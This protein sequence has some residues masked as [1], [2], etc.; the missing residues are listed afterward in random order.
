MTLKIAIVG[1][2]K[3]ADGHVEEIQKIPELA[4]VVAVADLELL[5]AE[6]LAVRYGLPAHYDDLA[7]LLD[8]QRPDVV[9]VTTP[10]QSHLALARQAIAA[11]AHV[12]VEK[13]LAP[14]Y[15]EARAL[16][17]LARGAGKKLTIG[18][19][20]YFDP[21]LAALR[22]L[23]EEGVLG[24]P[25][26]VESFLGY[27]LGSAFGKALL[28][29]PEHWVHRLPG[30]LFQN[31]LDHVLCKLP[32][33]LPDGRPDA[34]VEADPLG[35][36]RIRA[37]GWR[38]R[39]ERFGD[40]RDAMLDELRVELECEGTSALA[41]FSAHVRPATQ[42]V[43]VHGSRNTALAH[44]GMSTLTLDS[45]PR[46]PSALGRLG[47]AFGQTGQFFRAG[48]RNVGRFARNEFHYFTGLRCL[49]ERF[50]E[51]IASDGPPPIPYRDLLRVSAWMDEIWRQ[52]PQGDRP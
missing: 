10:P 37:H 32:A 52:V 1:C 25:V 45:E 23:H 35:A 46:L 5:M 18:Y 9:H 7:R 20:Y 44:H 51:C 16:V 42:L 24:A 2:G 30:K 31:N 19:S 17:A 49:F 34:E 36:T 4:R 26:H 41:W 8:E 39:P 11:G 28:A 21:P 14:T 27:G 15:A 40:V 3:I 48:A 50:Y 47:P 13:P 6:Q 38:R 29:D 43:R 22:Q 12:L 33:F